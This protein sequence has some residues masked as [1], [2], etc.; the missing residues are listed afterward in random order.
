MLKIAANFAELNHSGITTKITVCL[1]I[2]SDVYRIQISLKIITHTHR[3][4]GHDSG[5]VQY[6]AKFYGNF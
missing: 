4:F 5:V 3:S 6:C 1:V 2:F